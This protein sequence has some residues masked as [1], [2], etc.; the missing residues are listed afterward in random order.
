MSKLVLVRASDIASMQF[1]SVTDACHGLSSFHFAHLCDA[2]KSAVRRLISRV[3]EKSFRRGF[4][5]GYDSRKRGDAM[6]DL[7]QWRFST[8]L[9]YAVS[10]HGTYHNSS[11]QRLEIECHLR[12]VGLGDS[13]DGTNRQT[14]ADIL[15]RL[16]R[17]RRRKN[18]SAKLRFG[19]LRRDGFRCVYCGLTASQS[20][21]HVDHVVPV[22]DG[23]S[24]DI[25]NLVTSCIECNLGKGRTRV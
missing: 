13:A 22:V 23:G 18:M 1:D 6:C 16:F 11:D 25:E 7:H 12:R 15:S 10:A 17:I 2:D 21:L 3:S 24:D 14:W 5:Q 20:E 8:D 9:D 19:V 4:Q